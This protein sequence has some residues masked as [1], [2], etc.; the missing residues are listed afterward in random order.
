MGNCGLGSSGSEKVL[1][2]GSCEQDNE[3]PC[4]I[5]DVEIFD[6]LSDS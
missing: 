6:Y 1:M 2:A 5:K 4:S 3:L